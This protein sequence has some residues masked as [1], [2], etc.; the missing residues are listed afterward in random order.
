MTHSQ[1]D[2]TGGIPE[3]PQVY[4]GTLRGYREFRFSNE[5]LQPTGYYSG[6]YD[7]PDKDG[8]LTSTC[9]LKTV[10][11]DDFYPASEFGTATHVPDS[12]RIP[13]HEDPAPNR[14][15]KCGFYVNYIPGQSFHHCRSRRTYAHAVVDTSGHIV[16]GSK[17]YRAAKMRIVALWFPE[18]YISCEQR[19]AP[20][21]QIF[22]DLE[23]MYEAFPQ[24]DLTSLIGQKNQTELTDVAAA[25]LKLFKTYLDAD[26]Y[27]R[28]TIDNSQGGW[29]PT[30]GRYVV[31]HPNYGQTF[32]SGNIYSLLSACHC[33]DT[34]VCLECRTLCER[35]RDAAV[36][37]GVAGSKCHDAY[38]RRCNNYNF[39]QRQAQFVHRTCFCN[40]R[41][42]RN[43]Q[44]GHE[45]YVKLLHPLYPPKYNNNC[46]FPHCVFCN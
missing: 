39:R 35:T 24:E 36:S 30:K 32:S 12:K 10:I 31:H 37:S 22:T 4:P 19:S 6:T 23:E 5:G 11:L 2:W 42:C 20:K 8:W 16:L 38:C 14:T 40:K 7:E 44:L 17:G 9:T 46:G 13:V 41:V 27:D 15:C 29:R 43:C 45:E 28:V 34:L 33:S 3:P 1:V 26:F 21:A 18:E 25:E